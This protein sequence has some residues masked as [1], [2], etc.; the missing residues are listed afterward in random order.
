MTVWEIANQTRF[1]FFRI[2]I[3]IEAYRVFNL[4]GRFVPIITP[5]AHP[6]FS[7]RMFTL[8]VIYKFH[9]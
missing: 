2:S 5:H 7:S 1:R 8:Y 9:D 6:A 3:Y 4:H